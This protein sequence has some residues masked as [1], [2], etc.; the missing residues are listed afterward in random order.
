MPDAADAGRVL[1]LDYGSRRI[2]IAVGDLATGLA[3]GRPAL[4]RQGVDADVAAIAGL[5]GSEGAIRIV[6]GLP[7]H[8]GGEE[9]S[10]AALVRAF[11]E[12]LA[13]RGLEVA[14]HDERLTTWQ[15]AHELG[16]R[17]ARRRSGEVDSAAARLVLEDY[18]EATR[19]REGVR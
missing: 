11:G 6:L 3:F 15:A 17:A 9:G 5:A 4:R 10:Q 13:E 2:G 8:A 12:R 18:L 19:R 16:P 1:A 7:L 14:Y